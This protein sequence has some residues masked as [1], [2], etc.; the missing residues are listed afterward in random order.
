MKKILLPESAAMSSSLSC[1]Q[2]IGASIGI[3]MFPDDAE[4]MEQLIKCADEA[5]YKVKKSNKEGIVFY[6]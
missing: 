6:K 2:Y 3:S 5:M 1:Q 4:N